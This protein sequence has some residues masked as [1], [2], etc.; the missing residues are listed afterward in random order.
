M[1]KVA[2]FILIFIISAITSHIISIQ[3]LPGKI[4][5]VAM[6]KLVKERGV[7]LHQFVLSPRVTPQNQSIVRPSPDLA[8]S[9]CRFDF[10]R[11]N[12]GL[13]IFAASTDSYGPVSFYDANT[14][15]FDTRRVPEITSQERRPNGLRLYLVREENN[16]PG[17]QYFTGKSTG[18]G[19]AMVVLT[20]T[21]TGLVL[22]R[23]LSPTQD[24]YNDV[25]AIAEQDRCSPVSIN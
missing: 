23:R 9:V 25:A 17:M 7:P 8:Y 20:P 18:D 12:G 10:S 13:E 24:D 14:N 5:D 3:S 21:S 11:I 16:I 6:A 4:M 15:N 1:K 19:N 22:I 2:P